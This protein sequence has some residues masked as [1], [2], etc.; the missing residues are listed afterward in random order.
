MISAEVSVDP[1][2]AAYP[3]RRAELSV[4]L[5]TMWRDLSTGTVRGLHH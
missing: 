4:R 1:P 5:K 3:D 2:N